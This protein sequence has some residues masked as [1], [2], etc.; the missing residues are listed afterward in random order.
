MIVWGLAVIMLGMGITLSVDDITG[1]LAT[2]RPIAISAACW[3]ESGG[4]ARPT[5]PESGAVV[6]ARRPPSDGLFGFR[7]T[8]V[9]YDAPHCPT[10]FFECSSALLSQAAKR[11]R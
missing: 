2:P 9:R 4:S 1:V 7:F 10:I 8:F 3:R 6:K 5:K 11:Q